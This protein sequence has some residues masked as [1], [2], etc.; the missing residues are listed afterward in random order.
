MTR[1]E[2]TQIKQSK[3]KYNYSTNPEN[4]KILNI[5]TEYLVK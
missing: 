2:K 5:L 3:I 4:I 1:K